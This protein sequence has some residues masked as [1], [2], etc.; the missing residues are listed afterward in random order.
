MAGDTEKAVA[1]PLP[2]T[3]E[4]R[5]ALRAKYPE[6]PPEARDQLYFDLLAESARGSDVQAVCDFGELVFGHVAAAHHRA[7]IAQI[8]EHPRMAATAPPES[9]KTTWI[10][11]TVTAWWIGKHPER[12]NGICSAGDKAA[13]R[14][15]AVIADTIEKSPRWQMVFPHV[16]PD[17]DR[18]WSSDGYNVKDTRYSDG[19]WAALRYG[20]KDAT[21]LGAGV[22][23]AKWNGVR[24]TGIFV[25]DDIHDRKSKTQQATNDDTVGFFKDTAEYRATA[26]AHIAIM[27]TRWNPKDIIAYCKSRPS[28]KVF[29][30]PAILTDADGVEYSYWPEHHSIE[31]LQEKRAPAPVEFELVFQGNDKA[32]EG[33]VLKT[34]WLHAF[35]HLLIKT[36]WN[37]YFGLDPAKRVKEIFNK[38]DDPDNF[39]IAC[40]ADTGSR[41]V[42]EDVWGGV[43]FAPDA[44]DLYFSKAA[45]YKPRRTGIEI[46]GLGNEYY[47]NFLKRMRVSGLAYVLVKVVTSRDMGER[48]SELSPYYAS[49]QLL[50]SDADTPGLARF[51]SQWAMFPRG[52]DDALSAAHVAWRVAQFLLPSENAET[53][54]QRQR[55]FERTVAPFAAIDKAYG[56]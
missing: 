54:K 6:L 3:S 32:V 7:W 27:Q 49:G 37:R 38:D 5:A 47:L 26:T 16:V 40:Y 21:L 24:I 33:T 44:E 51:R 28:F 17:K 18:G 14:M 4:L 41:L 20:Q 1:P 36:E 52:H 9:A 35:D 43:L 8:L 48:M 50:I 45:L 11:Q 30:H 10:T 12:T 2:D 42:L 22:G 53:V 34:E 25:L 29:E 56:R 19:E 31:S 39:E 46:N 15:A 13:E 23:S 55:A